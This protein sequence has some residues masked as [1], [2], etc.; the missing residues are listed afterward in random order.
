MC[1]VS[2]VSTGGAGIPNQF[3]TRDTWA[4]YK[5]ILELLKKLDEK[6]G[7]PDCVDPKKDAWMRGVEARLKLLEDDCQ[8]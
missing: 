4:E 1:M 8:E 2:L 5:E 3:W 6:L 7:Q